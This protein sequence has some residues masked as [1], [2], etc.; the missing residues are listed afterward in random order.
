VRLARV[1]A[2]F[3]VFLV[4]LTA[5]PATALASSDAMIERINDA[6]ARHGLGP[7]KASSALNGSARRYAATLMRQ[8][9]LAHRA[10]PSVGGGFRR[11]GEILAMHY[12]RGDRVGR[13]LSRWMH[14]GSHRPILLTRSMRLVGAGV[15]HG[16][17]RGG[18]AA[19]W[20]VQV[21]S[22]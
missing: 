19:I 22:R 12:G 8:D 4:P 1:L 7:L 2:L 17:F 11:S 16:N 6:R 9:V 20:V 10:G 5:L 21:G 15:V 14:S 3:A 13:T 18:R